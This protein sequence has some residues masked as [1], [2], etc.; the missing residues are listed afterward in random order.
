MKGGGLTGPLSFI[1]RDGNNVLYEETRKE[2][3]L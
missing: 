2:G 1:F 3:L